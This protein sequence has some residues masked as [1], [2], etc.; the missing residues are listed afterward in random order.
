MTQ[1]SLPLPPYCSQL[2]SKHKKILRC[3][4]H[5]TSQV[6]LVVKNST[7]NTGDIRDVGLNPGLGRFPGGGHDNSLQ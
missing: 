3:A 5:C 1:I 6:A 7:A 4:V 2:F